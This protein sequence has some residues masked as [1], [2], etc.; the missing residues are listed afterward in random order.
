MDR[1]ICAG[2][3]LSAVPSF[4][5][6]FLKVRRCLGAENN[7]RICF[8]CDCFERLQLNFRVPALT[9]AGYKKY[10]GSR[11]I[12]F[13]VLGLDFNSKLSLENLGSRC[14]PN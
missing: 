7:A 6:D 13:F 10:V 5:T 9:K 1:I 12:G 8:D 14:E 11:I 4:F 3:D 2:N